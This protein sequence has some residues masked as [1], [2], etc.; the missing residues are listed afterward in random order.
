M[1][2]RTVTAVGVVFRRGIS[3]E[4]RQLTQTFSRG[5]GAR[6]LQDCRSVNGHRQRRFRLRRRDVRTGHDNALGRGF[7]AGGGREG[8]V[9]H[10][11][12]SGSPSLLRERA[13]GDE[14]RNS[15]ADYESSSG[16]ILTVL[17]VF[18]IISFSMVFG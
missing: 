9:W 11:S 5:V 3:D 13:R 6:F 2:G 17:D 14:E 8:R 10:A 15:D 4:G 12:G 7:A 16:G 18:R 1:T